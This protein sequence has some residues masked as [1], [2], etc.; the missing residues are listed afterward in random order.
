MLPQRRSK[1][2]YFGLLIGNQSDVTTFYLTHS[3]IWI[4]RTDDRGCTSKIET[5]QHLN[6]IL[7]N[8][9][10]QHNNSNPAPTLRQRHPWAVGTQLFTI[11][12][13]RMQPEG[14]LPPK[15]KSSYWTLSSATSIDLISNDIPFKV[16]VSH[17]FWR[18]SDDY[19]PPPP[20]KIP[21]PL[22]L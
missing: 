7:R 15:Q 10:C 22:F 14:Y 11:F 13:A 21:W 4:T 8:L 1:C 18:P 16:I 5:L 9:Y 19:I 3:P 6:S 20:K 17:C 12:L 2:T